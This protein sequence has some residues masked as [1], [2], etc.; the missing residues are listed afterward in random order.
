[1]Q[2]YVLV[3]GVH[4][5]SLDIRTTRRD[6]NGPKEAEENGKKNEKSRNDVNPYEHLQVNI[7]IRGTALL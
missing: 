2:G 3:V 7:K 6:R 5:S 1:M 4:S